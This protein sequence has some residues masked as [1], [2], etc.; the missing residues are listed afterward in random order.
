MLGSLNHL[1]KCFYPSPLP[2][3]GIHWRGRRCRWQFAVVRP[4]R[5]ACRCRGRRPGRHRSPGGRG[6]GWRCSPGTQSRTAWAARPAPERRWPRRPGTGRRWEGPGEAGGEIW[7]S[8][9]GVV[10]TSL[11]RR[12]R[13]WERGLEAKGE[14]ANWISHRHSQLIT[15]NIV[16]VELTATGGED[17]AKDV[18][19]S[20]STRGCLLI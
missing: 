8:L 15:L 6:C 7:F 5:W 12:S 13:G 16:A 1:T 14:W 3:P 9:G 10:V 4:C 2:E 17:G 19:W 18:W 20:I 11:G